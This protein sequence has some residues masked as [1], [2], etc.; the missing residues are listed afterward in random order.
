MILLTS[1]GGLWWQISDANA[2]STDKVQVNVYKY[3]YT[4][5]SSEE[6]ETKI[7]IREAAFVGFDLTDEYYQSRMTQQEFIDTYKALTS[8]D[9]QKMVQEKK[10]PILTDNEASVVY[11]NPEG[12]VSWSVAKEKNGLAAVYLFAETRTRD[13]LS[14]FETY[15]QPM[16]LFLPAFDEESGKPLS[17]IDL[18]PKTISYSCTP[19][20]FKYGKKLDGTVKRLSG[21]N[22]VLSRQ[23][24]GKKEYWSVDQPNN[25]LLSHWVSSNDPKNDS[26]VKTFISDENGLVSLGN[27]LLPIG[28][29]L[30]EE[31]AAPTGYEIDSNSRSIRVDVQG[32]HGEQTIDTILIN[33]EPLERNAFGNVSQ[34]VIQVGSPKIYNNEKSISDLEEKGLPTSK[35]SEGKLLNTGELTSDMLL[36][37]IGF[38]LLAFILWKQRNHKTDMNG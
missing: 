7:P 34:A 32:S 10:F 35:E 5:E 23:K 37:G 16:L 15:S 31:V 38:I 19:Y 33:N 13:D 4:H 17:V 29:Y 11:T 27:Y 20:F 8:D 24:D 2:N 6:I 26:H 22:F 30:F 21:A 1:F 3:L 18:F 36:L 14:I 25:I 28:S 9:I 12:K